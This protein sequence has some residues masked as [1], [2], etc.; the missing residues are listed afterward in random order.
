MTPTTSMRM[1]ISER[2]SAARA[3]TVC[4]FLTRFLRRGALGA[5]FLAINISKI[6]DSGFFYRAVFGAWSAYDVFVAR[7]FLLLRC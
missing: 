3:S 1:R 2:V 6:G 5:G 7:R 4:S